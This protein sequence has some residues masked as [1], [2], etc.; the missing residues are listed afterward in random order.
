MGEVYRARD[1]RLQRDVA[2][3]ILPAALASDPVHVERFRREARAVAALTHPNIVTI[4][5]VEEADGVHFLTMELIDGQPLD[6]ERSTTDRPLAQVLEIGMA[7]ADALTAAH[8]RGI[9]HRDLK[10]AN[11]MVDRHGRVKILDFGLAKDITIEADK[12]GTVVFLAYVDADRGE[13]RIVHVFPDAAAMDRHMQ[14]AD[15]RS[16]QA[17]QFLEP[18]EIDVYGAPSAG[19]IAEIEGLA[20]H[21]VKLTL[22]PGSVGGYLR[23]S[24]A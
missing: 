23:P 20:G 3:K 10:P 21:G 1:A 18:L 2:L 5:S 11:V 12:P 4:H 6:H 22:M 14:G 9:V 13:T 7:L 19:V 24:S 17:Y 8:E 15:E 16:A